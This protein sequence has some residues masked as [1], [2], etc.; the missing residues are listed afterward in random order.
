MLTKPKARTAFPEFSGR[1]IKNCY[2]LFEVIFCQRHC[3]PATVD[4]AKSDF[5]HFHFWRTPRKIAT[6]IFNF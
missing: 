2:L 4:C 3:A 1:A 5:F 6:S